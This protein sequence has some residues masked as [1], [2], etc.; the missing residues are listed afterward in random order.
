MQVWT[1][2]KNLQ[3]PFFQSS[4]CC[5][6][7][8]TTGDQQWSDVARMTI[9]KKLVHKCSHLKHTAVSNRQP[10]EIIYYWGS[11]SVVNMV[12]DYPGNSVLNDL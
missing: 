5:V 6:V 1:K 12:G 7:F 3:G 2:L 10:V 11:P 8:A 9:H 4:S